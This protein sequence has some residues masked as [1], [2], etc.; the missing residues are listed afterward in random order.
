MKKMLI[1][2]IALLMVM[3]IGGAASAAPSLTIG[4]AAGNPFAELI[5]AVGGSTTLDIYATVV[6]DGNPTVAGPYSLQ[7]FGIEMSYNAALLNVTAASVDP[8]WN[9]GTPLVDFAMDGQ[10]SLGGANL[11]GI[12]SAAFLGSITFASE[13]EVG[14]TDL[15]VADPGDPIFRMQLTL[16]SAGGNPADISDQLPQNIG[17][18][19]TPIPGSILLLGSGLV[20]LIGIAR[21]KRS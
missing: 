12:A 15:I 14:V 4:D 5:P 16:A 7:G 8:Q 3:G 6:D 21:R 18:I 9:F 17:T 10:V 13:G 2:S 1:C 11:S 20:G 19:A